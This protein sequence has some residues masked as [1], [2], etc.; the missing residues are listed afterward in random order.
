MSRKSRSSKIKGTN[1][2]YSSFEKFRKAKAFNEVSFEEKFCWDQIIVM[3]YIDLSN[4]ELRPIAAEF[5]RTL[6][7]IEE[8]LPYIEGKKYENMMKMFNERK[9]N[10]IY[11]ILDTILGYLFPL[12]LPKL[13]NSA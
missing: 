2:K 1:I 9:F 3:E 12:N 6:P 8:F 5:L 7:E 13:K 11:E 10:N 4:K